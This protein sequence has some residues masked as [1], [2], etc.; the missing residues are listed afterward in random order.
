MKQVTRSL[1]TF[2]MLGGVGAAV[3]GYAWIKAGEAEVQAVPEDKRVF[4]IPPARFNRV[5]IKNQGHVVRLEEEGGQWVV[6][7]PARISADPGVVKELLTQAVRIRAEQR[8]G[9]PGAES[10]PKDEL[11]GLDERAAMLLAWREGEPKT[12]IAVAL[13]IQSE[14][15][16]RVYA[17]VQQGEGSAEIVMVPGSSKT[18]LIKPATQLYDRRVL[19]ASHER[20]RR[21]T[22]EPREPSEERILFTLERIKGE[23]DKPLLGARPRYKVI[24]PPLGEADAFQVSELLKALA[25]VPVSNFV[26]TE[27]GGDFA[28]YGLDPPEF[29]LT[30]TVALEAPGG[31]ERLVERRI[32]VGAV[33]EPETE[34]GATSV[35]VAR[36]DQP[37]IGEVNASLFHALPHTVDKLKS[38]RLID[39]DREQVRRIEMKLKEAGNITLERT[40]PAGGGAPGWRLLAPEPGPAKVYVVNRFLLT[41]TRLV[42]LSREAEGKQAQDPAVL[43]R[44]GLADEAQTVAFYGEGDK[45]LGAIRLGKV[46]EDD[47]FAM[48]EGG[49]FIVRVPKAKL[50]EIP[51][52]AAELLE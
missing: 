43:E 10:V 21:L 5:E 7:E 13:G 28:K 25:A 1:L 14:F 33:R 27:H 24:E 6:T 42:G 52:S 46:K 44:T 29:I 49:E 15:N 32:R 50:R 26:S 18:Q 36:E 48:A 30:A 31:E 9:K 45:L 34:G 23:S 17:R 47:L 20:V 40:E 22:V 8:L 38:K 2:A 37:W 3:G 12:R 41:F 4:D 11:T 35:Y 39:V 51:L 19:G 16:H